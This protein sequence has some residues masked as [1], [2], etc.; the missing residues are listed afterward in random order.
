LTRS[1]QTQ[2]A[3]QTISGHNTGYRSHIFQSPANDSQVWLF[4]N[5]DLFAMDFSRNFPMELDLF[6][7]IL[8]KKTLG[9]RYVLFVESDTFKL[10]HI[11]EKNFEVI[12]ITN[13]SSPACLMPVLTF[14]EF[15]KVASIDRHLEQNHIKDLNCI[16]FD[17]DGIVELYNYLSGFSPDTIRIILDMPKLIRCFFQSVKKNRNIYLKNT[18]QDD[19]INDGQDGKKIDVPWLKDTESYLKVLFKYSQTN[20][21][22]NTFKKIRG[23]ILHGP[24]GNSKTKLIQ[25]ICQDDEMNHIIVTASEI[26]EKY[27]GDSEKAVKNFFKRAR[28]AAPCILVFDEMESLFLDRDINSASGTVGMLGIVTTLLFEMDSIEKQK[29][30]FVVGTTNKLEMVDQAFLRPGRFDIKIKIDYPKETEIAIIVDYFFDLFYTQADTE[31][32]KEYVKKEADVLNTEANKEYVKK[33]VIDRMTAAK[34]D[35]TGLT[36]FSIADISHIV[37]MIEIERDFDKSQ[38]GNLTPIQIISKI[39]GNLCE[40]KDMKH[41]RNAGETERAYC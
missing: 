40:T 28:Q 13:I 1:T 4:Y 12:H 37:K 11:F 27:L 2:A 5:F 36:P 35:Q 26:K 24:P 25:K 19:F 29:N 33:E 9:L 7:S 38:K 22:K 15:K 20:V 39:I 14:E 41:K 18:I 32:N 30:V 10:P 6:Y 23:I 21:S 17:Q 3:Y 34:A 8:E 31:A 16:Q